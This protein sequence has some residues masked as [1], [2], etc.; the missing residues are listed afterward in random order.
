MKKLRV[1]IL[2]LIGCSTIIGMALTVDTKN[3][4]EIVSR[5]QPTTTE[6]QKQSTNSTLLTQAESA[7]MRSDVPPHIRYFFLFRHLSNIKDTAGATRFQAKAGLNPEQLQ[8][9]T[10]IAINNER[11]VKK[12]DEQA[13]A[14]ITVFHKQYPPGK[15]PPGMAPPA[16]PLQ[17]GVLQRQREETILRYRQQLQS[18][19]GEEDFARFDTFVNEESGRKTSL[20][21]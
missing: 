10:S 7:P 5:S 16:L 20:R 17:I 12:L 11:E 8:T 13:E 14:I 2:L 6:L 3:L 19:L 18:I 4:F 1:P 9:L 15:M 21:N